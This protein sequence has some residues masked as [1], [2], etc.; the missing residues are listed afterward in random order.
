MSEKQEITEPA[1]TEPAMTEQVSK[2]TFSSMTEDEINELYKTSVNSKEQK[3]KDRL[4]E[5]LIWNFGITLAQ[6]GIS[7]VSVKVEEQI[8]IR[9]K[10]ES[11]Q[12]ERDICITLKTSSKNIRDD[13]ENLFSYTF[14]LLHL[15]LSNSLL[16]KNVT[17]WKIKMSDNKV[18]YVYIVYKGINLPLTQAKFFAENGEFDQDKIFLTLLQVC[19]SSHKYKDEFVDSITFEPIPEYDEIVHIKD[20]PDYLYGRRTITSWLHQNPTSPFTRRPCKLE[21]LVT[22]PRPL[23][24]DEIPNTLDLPSNRKYENSLGVIKINKE[25][26]PIGRGCSD[27]TGIELF[28]QK[29]E[30]IQRS[31]TH[32]N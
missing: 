25:H 30:K 6:Y 14:S 10:N 12:Y 13:A 19:R 31:L 17:K 11:N 7:V 23:P 1:M 29:A 16:H 24:I 27:T 26:V 15:I 5:Y 28:L 32:N 3:E 20:E 2:D 9:I 21:D 18:T 8:K 22:I 4:R